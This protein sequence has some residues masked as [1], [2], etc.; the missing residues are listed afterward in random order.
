MT[1]LDLGRARGDLR[2]MHETPG[3]SSETQVMY[4]A[5]GHGVEPMGHPQEARVT[6]G[7]TMET[8]GLSTRLH[9]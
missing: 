2:R 7:H 1:W 6:I 8:E 4:E 5:P 3:H 9:V